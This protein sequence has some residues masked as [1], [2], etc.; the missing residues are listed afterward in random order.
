MPLDP[1]VAALLEAQAGAPDFCDLPLA[2]ARERM[3]GLQEMSGE[4]VAIGAVVELAVA[5]A[6]GPLPATLHV[7]AEAPDRRA[8]WPGILYFHGG[9]WVG[10][11]RAS[12]AGTCRKLAAWSGCAVLAVDYRLAPEHHFPA[13][14]EDGQAAFR[15]LR[16]NAAGL[17]LDADWLAV[18]GGSAGANLALATALAVRDAGEPPP[19]HLLLAYPVVDLTFDQPSCVE[20]GDGYLL[21][22][23]TM[24]WFAGHYLADPADAASPLSSPLRADLRGLPPAH[25][26]IAE[27]DPLRDQQEALVDRLDAAGVPV[28]RLLAGGLI[29]GFLGMSSVLD[30]A[31]GHLRTAASA[32]GAAARQPLA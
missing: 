28:T 6:A 21:T 31:D 11:S 25:V 1:Q 24:K 19:A 13:A 18:G 15:W 14:V 29:H 26:T 4:P 32:L 22:T 2:E 8:L 30:A 27:F 17:G 20:L 23:R 10:G 7:P 9:G 5:G 16:G 3:R 12:I